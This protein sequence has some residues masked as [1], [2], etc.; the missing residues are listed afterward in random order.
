MR[1]Q[2]T[3]TLLAWASTAGF[4]IAYHVAP[5]VHEP[6]VSHALPFVCFGSL[7]AS[8]C[9]FGLAKFFSSREFAETPAASQDGFREPSLPIKIGFYLLALLVFGRV[10]FQLNAPLHW[11]DNFHFSNVVNTPWE[12]FNPLLRTE[13]HPLTNLAAFV[14]VNLFG[15]S[16][17][18][19]KF[20]ALCFTLILLS[21]VL[22]QSQ[23]RLSRFSALLLLL[24]LGSNQITIWYMHSMRAYILA[25]GIGLG[26][27]S[28][29]QSLTQAAPP[30]PKR[31]LFGMGLLCYAAVFTHLFATL[32]C[33][34]SFVSLLVWSLIHRKTLSQP[35]RK[36]IGQWFL[37]FLGLVVPTYLFI[38]FHQALWLERL[39]DLFRGGFP[40]LSSTLLGAL[41][42]SFGWSGRLALVLNACVLFKIA[43]D[44]PEWL[45]DFPSIFLGVTLLFF[46]AILWVLQVRLIE[47]RFILPFL[48]PTLLW[49]G[50]S[51]SK[52]KAPS[53]RRMAMALAGLVFWIVPWQSSRGIYNGLTLNVAEF[54]QFI[55][56]VQKIT[57]PMKDNCY[58]FSGEPNLIYF[59]Q[60]LY[61]GPYQG[62]Q[63]KSDCKTHYHLYFESPKDLAPMDTRPDRSGHYEVVAQT[64][65]RMILY[66]EV[67]SSLLLS[68]EKPEDK[69]K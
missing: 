60:S 52:I 16:K 53:T 47:T 12:R 18:A 43:K 7:L 59:S 25:M 10:L 32:F 21:L 1:W 51:I 67:P 31:T 11:E 13:H 3:F 48:I 38:L 23:H 5:W 64:G 62:V 33:I 26:L 14:S 44:E 20:P 24:H 58:T 9:S 8:L 29:L 61:L 36:V 57:A 2:R 15:M 40:D 69:I 55:Q 39:G 65:Q 50:E 41:G 54:D 34:L 46:S 28:L 22:W 35:Q 4:L 56:K 66:R 30:H 37:V 27:Y 68:Q 49:V 42:S 19:I 45:V 63:A 17:A 6:T